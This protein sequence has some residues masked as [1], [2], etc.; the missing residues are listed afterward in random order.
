MIRPLIVW[1]ILVLIFHRPTFDLFLHMTSTHDFYLPDFTS[2]LSILSNHIEYS[3]RLAPCYTLPFFTILKFLYPTDQLAR[4]EK[5]TSIR[6]WGCPT[7]RGQ[8][9]KTSIKPSSNRSDNENHVD[10]LGSNKPGLF[11]AFIGPK[12]F[13]R[14]TAL[15]KPSQSPP[16][17]LKDPGVNWY[18]Q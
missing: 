10:Y 18:S 5:M 13:I 11:K 8:T 1:K 3:K 2:K 15:T 12:T 16:S 4:L 7:Q 14:F 6:K 17:I 9:S